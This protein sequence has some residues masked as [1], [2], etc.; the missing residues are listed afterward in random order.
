MT[1]LSLQPN[2]IFLVEYNE[3]DRGENTLSNYRRGTNFKK[4][5]NIFI[6]QII[7]YVNYF[8]IIL[9]CK[10]EKITPHQTL[11]KIEIML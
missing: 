8:K 5:T 4:L 2:V 1:N 3:K 10:E 7:H 11:N 9:I 6:N